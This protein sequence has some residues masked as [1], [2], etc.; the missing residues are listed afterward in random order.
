MGLEGRGGAL[1]CSAC[2]GELK[3][4]GDD[5]ATLGA[6]GRAG[7]GGG[8]GG[9]RAAVAADGRLGVGRL[10]SGGAGGREVIGGGGQPTSCERARFHHLSFAS[11]DPSLP[12]VNAAHGPLSF[13]DVPRQQTV[14]NMA[15]VLGAGPRL[16][17]HHGVRFS[18]VLCYAFRTVV[19]LS[20]AFKKRR[21]THVSLA[22]RPTSRLHNTQGSQRA[23]MSPR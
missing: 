13:R 15:R 2:A 16:G 8:S 7:S 17:L 23:V 1:A 22:A 19:S 6:S 10:G 4:S 18:P 11:T 12:C 20:C 3:S 21:L 9:G 14:G 5:E